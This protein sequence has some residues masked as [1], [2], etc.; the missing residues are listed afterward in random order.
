MTR[1]LIMQKASAIYL[2]M[3]GLS[4]ASDAKEAL[5]DEQQLGKLLYEDENLSLNRNQSCSSCHSLKPEPKQNTFPKR[6]SVFIDRDNVK[7]GT[8][9]SLGSIPDATGA[10]NAPSVGYAA[11]S[12]L[13]LWND[14]EG[15]YVGGQFWNGRASDL[16]EQAKGPLLNP[17][18]MA[19]PSEWSVVSRLKEN[20]KYQKLFWQV[21]GINL[22]AVPYINNKQLNVIT[23]AAVT[24]T[25]HHMAKAISAFEQS[26]VFNKF[27]S[28]F[29]YVLANMTEFSQIEKEG[30]AL[31]ND[32][33]KG[34]CAA[35]HI[36][37]V[38]IDEDGDVIPPMFTDFTYDNIGLPRNVKIPKNPEPDSGLGGR[39]DI[40][41]LD[42][43]GNEI[44]K[45]KVM[46]LRNIALTAPYGH[47]GVFTTLEQIVHFYN[48]RDTLGWVPDNQDSGFA[49]L[50]WPDP[51]ISQN[52]NHD[53]LGNLGLVID[54]EKAIVAFMK[55]LTDDYPKWGKDRRVPPGTPS[56]FPE[57]KPPGH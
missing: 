16:T 15:L 32:E 23:P 36:S 8:A 18:E 46:S 3:L 11:F 45:H 7:K 42:P 5:T 28:K 38:S 22:A 35:C 34:N 56:P 9:V 48:T 54:E 12:P 26:P 37:E 53:E 10:L 47:N 29:D 17:V 13:F 55:T 41:A 2:L 1:Y 6:V 57:V 52:V 50:G 25:Y 20:G 43:D 30:L 24:E 44:G 21:Y 51:E 33:T 31:F 14:E 49:T 40:A 19:M 39:S 4:F 27:T